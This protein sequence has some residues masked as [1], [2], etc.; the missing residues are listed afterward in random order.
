[1][2]LIKQLNDRITRRAAETKAP[3]KSYSSEAR[4]EA[5]ATELAEKVA[6]Y[7]GTDRPVRFVVFKAE[8]L[9]R[10][11]ACFDMSELMSRPG[12]T[13]GYMGHIADAGH[14]TY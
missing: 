11:V 14:F 4:A 1:M 5:A 7:H 10:W 3:C 12:C 6:K 13:A 9:N 2:S 8:A